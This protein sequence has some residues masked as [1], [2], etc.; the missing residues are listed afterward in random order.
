MVSIAN[1]RHETQ[2][3]G[4]EAAIGPATDADVSGIVAVLHANRADPSLYRRAPADVRRHVGEFIVARD[5]AGRVLGCAALHR[6]SRELA[7]LLSVA[8]LPDTQGG[9]IGARLVEACTTRA[10][11]QGIPR[12]WLATLKPGY[13]ARFGYRPIPRWWLPPAVLLGLLALV[14]RQPPD[15]WRNALLGREAFMILDLDG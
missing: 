10:R 11:A 8:V 1:D 4:R 7:E 6:D 14:V 3:P 13:F 2:Q 12:I 5:A 15:R 9:G